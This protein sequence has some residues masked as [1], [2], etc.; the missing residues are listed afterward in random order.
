MYG[1]AQ[2]Q[3]VGRADDDSQLEVYARTR[4]LDRLIVVHPLS[5][6]LQRRAVTCDGGL[7][8]VEVILAVV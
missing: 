8:V 7:A 6:V 1:H 2:T 4:Y 3:P 5:G